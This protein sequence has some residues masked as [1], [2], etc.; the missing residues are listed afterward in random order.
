MNENE[1]IK[2][3]KSYVFNSNSIEGFK[4]YSFKEEV[5]LYNAIIAHMEAKERI[6]NS[7]MEFLL[8][9]DDPNL[10]IYEMIFISIEHISKMPLL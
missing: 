1:L 3:C 10:D 4:P 6:Y 8:K 9:K 7:I 5:S 2:E